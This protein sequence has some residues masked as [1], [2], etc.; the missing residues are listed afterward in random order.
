MSEVPNPS[1][2]ERICCKCGSDR[3]SLRYIRSL[4]LLKCICIAC[5]YNW[6]T[7]P[8]DAKPDRVLVP[9]MEEAA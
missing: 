4:D 8:L 2:T 9:D 6:Q 7:L 5:A 3:I 1:S